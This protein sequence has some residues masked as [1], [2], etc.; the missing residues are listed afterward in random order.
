[1][2]QKEKLSNEVKELTLSEARAVRN[3]IRSIRRKKETPSKKPIKKNAAFLTVRKALKNI[4]GS[5][6]EEIS[7]ERED[8]I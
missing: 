8:R 4:K 7:I 6:S 1:M 2:S 3:F 5:L